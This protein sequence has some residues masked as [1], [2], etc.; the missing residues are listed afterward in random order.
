MGRIRVSTVINAPPATVWAHVEDVAEHV[1]WM[2]DAVAIR[3][4]SPQRT[5]KGTTFDCETRV[6]PLQLTDTM[7]VTEWRRGRAMAVRHV[8]TVKGTGRFTLRRVRGGRTRFTWTE[9]L[10][11]PWWMGGP[12]TAAAAAVVMRRIWRRNLANLKALVEGDQVAP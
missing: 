9:T 11:F 12:A 8:G 10:R 4:V 1:R 5:G 7:E 6:G 3:I 2:N